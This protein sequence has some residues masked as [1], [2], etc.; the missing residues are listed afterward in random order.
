[1]IGIF[2][3]SLLL[4]CLGLVAIIVSKCSKY[5][6]LLNVL[7][8]TGLICAL[9]GTISLIVA[10]V[11]LCVSILWYDT[12]QMTDIVTQDF[13]PFLGDKIATGANACFNDTNLAVAF[14]VTDKVDFQAKLDEGLSAKNTR[15]GPCYRVTTY[16]RQQQ[17]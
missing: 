1:M 15:S 6:P 5:K 14:N 7:N 13:E 16:R 2:V 9:L 4:P 8:I 11:V 17:H 3:V 12:C 10:S